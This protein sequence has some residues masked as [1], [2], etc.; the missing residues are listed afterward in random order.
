MQFL[1]RLFLVAGLALA[2]ASTAAC[3]DDDDDDGS[4]A[5]GGAGGSSGSGG[6]ATGGASGSGGTAGSGG[7]SGSGG[8]A[9]GG[10]AGA[11]GM[12]AATIVDVAESAGFDSLLAAAERAGL[13][14]AL[15]GEG[16]LTVFAPTDEAFAEFLGEQSLEDIPPET[17]AD[18]LRYHVVAD[19]VPAA[20]VVELTT[21]TTLLGS[22]LR[23]T[24]EGE[25]VFLNG[26]TRVTM[27]DVMASNG[28]IHV[29]DQVLMPPGDIPAV[30][31]SAGFTSL[32][33][34]VTRAGL[35]ETLQ[36]EG[37]FTVF[38]PTDEAFSAFLSAQGVTLEQLTPEQLQPILLYH[39][40]PA[41]LYSEDVVEA[42]SATTA[43]GGTIAISVAEGG[44]V[45]NGEV[46][47]TQVDV[48]ASNGVIHVIDQVLV[49]ASD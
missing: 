3:S 10:S 5:T 4:S 35:V 48:L 18:V 9:T 14:E 44:V 7:S 39:V 49:P 16:P 30:A 26:D 29:I 12:S 42:T 22:D 43:Q 11:G 47:V 34:A 46:N 24:T 36:G 37:P 23:I 1:N 31:T 15:A 25:N 17:L 20:E 8:S 21:A 13:G 2:A 41:K 38:A 40:V 6:S 19:S 33:A 45:L 32:V 28:I 27:T